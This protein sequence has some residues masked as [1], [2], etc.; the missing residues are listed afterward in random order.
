MSNYIYYILLAS[1]FIDTYKIFTVQI[2]II[3]K[4]VKRDNPKFK[5]QNIFD[6]FR[7]KKKGKRSDKCKF[8]LF[9]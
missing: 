4:F 7:R 9:F 6:D 1:V 3:N 2:L 5:K 8:M